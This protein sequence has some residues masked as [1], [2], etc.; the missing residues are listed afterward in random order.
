MRLCMDVHWAGA[1]V[2]VAEEP[3]STRAFFAALER[4]RATYLYLTPLHLRQLLPG[5]PDDRVGFPAVRG[6][7]PGSKAVGQSLRDR[8]VLR[9]PPN[10]VVADGTN[11]VGSPLAL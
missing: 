3:A 10:L 2:V 11:E 9:F 1:T 5:L 7:R 4:S 8:V 6:L